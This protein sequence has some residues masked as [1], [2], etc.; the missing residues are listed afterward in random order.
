MNN[1]KKIV[2]I[3]ILEIAVAIVSWI[4]PYT[5]MDNQSVSKVELV[6]KVISKKADD[7]WRFVVFMPT[8]RNETLYSIFVLADNNKI[9]ECTCNEIEFEEIK[10]GDSISFIEDTRKSGSIYHYIK[11]QI[12]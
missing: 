10:E 12:I 9:Y 1:I 11:G 4:I 7:S 2:A 8:F 6:A 5:I 3:S